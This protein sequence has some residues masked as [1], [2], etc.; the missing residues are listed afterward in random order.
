L[1]FGFAGN[2]FIPYHVG[3]KD[4]AFPR[5]NNFGF[6]VFPAGFILVAK[7][8]FLRPSI[9]KY[10]D[11]PSFFYKLLEKKS[12]NY[13][14]KYQD[15][16]ISFMSKKKDTIYY[17]RN[18]E[19]GELEEMY[20]NNLYSYFPVKYLKNFFFNN[21]FSSYWDFSIYVLKTRR[22]KIVIAKSPNSASTM[23]G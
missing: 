8:A 19:T 11:K 4:V 16:L 13:D 21:N 15:N 12:V 2:F 18:K 6:W 22:K 5:L 10:F 9:I 7:P 23:S 20:Q 17:V 14:Y 1:V 3:S